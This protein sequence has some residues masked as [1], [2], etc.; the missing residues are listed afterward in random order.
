MTPSTNSTEPERVQKFLS[1]AG[2][3]SRRRAEALIRAGRVAVNGVIVSNLGTKIDSGVDA[4]TVDGLSVAPP[5]RLRY[6]IVNKQAGVVTTLEDPQ[7][8]PTVAQYVPE[9]GPRLFPVGRLDRE[10]TGLLLM[11]N[12]GELA[13]ALMHPRFHVPKT[14]RA[15]VGGVPDGRDLDRLREGIDLDDG[16]T[17]PAE[18]QLLDQRA[19]SATVLLTLREGRKRQVR[20]M[21]SAIGHPVTALARVAYGPLTDE[22]LP[23]GDARELTT[24]EVRALQDAVAGDA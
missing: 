17:A 14:Y 21:F 7:G 15:L 23:L 6:L 11:T 19:D 24:D 3:A 2:V 18:V 5:E 4:V 1:R 20:R 22:G 10:T 8:R 9:D 16:R 13:H 12:D